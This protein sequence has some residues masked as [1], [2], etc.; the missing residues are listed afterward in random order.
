MNLFSKKP[1]TRKT[2]VLINLLISCILLSLISGNLV[3]ANVITDDILNALEKKYT[4]KSFT[5]NFNQISKLAAL[6]ITE[7][8]S[9]KASFSH[10]GKMN[11][12]YLEPEVHKIITDGV[13]L[14]IYQPDE[15]QVMIGD[16]ENFFKSGAGGAFLSDISLIRKNYTIKVK[17][18]AADYVEIDMIAKT[19]TPEISSIV[20]RISQK[21]NEILRVIT[22]NEVNDTTLFE[23]YDIQF[24]KLNPA[25][26]EFTPPEGSNIIDLN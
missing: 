26:F 9:G 13:S 23:F 2:T 4:G 3:G 24:K 19:P 17:E 14:W 25:I 16:A 20:I 12:E 8:A 21:T 6:E 22:Y 15:N 10:P 11:W 1:T 5:A 18:M 7:K